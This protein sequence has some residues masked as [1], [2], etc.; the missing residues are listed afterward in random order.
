[1]ILDP[2]KKFEAVAITMH[3]HSNNKILAL[4]TVIKQY[5]VSQVQTLLVHVS[6]TNLLTHKS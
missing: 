6:L 2:L 1:M 3:D 4:E 5:A